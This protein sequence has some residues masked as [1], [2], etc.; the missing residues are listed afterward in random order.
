MTILWA[1]SFG[2][3]NTNT[4][5]DTNFPFFSGFFENF[6]I[7]SF[8]ALGAKKPAL[9]FDKGFDDRILHTF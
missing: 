1:I 5:K 3:T 4:R 7:L 2:T 6:C 9:E 8:L